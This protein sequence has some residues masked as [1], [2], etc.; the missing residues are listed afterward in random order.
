VP[1]VLREFA[2]KYDVIATGA[3][4]LAERNHVEPVGGVY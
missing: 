3:K 1:P 2:A 4:N